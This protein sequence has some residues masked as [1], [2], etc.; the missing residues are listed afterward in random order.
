M[1]LGVKGDS[2]PDNQYTRRIGSARRAQT[3]GFSV[4]TGAGPRERYSKRIFKTGPHLASR[5][6]EDE[7]VDPDVERA[8]RADVEGDGDGDSGA[9]N[10]DEGPNPDP[11]SVSPAPTEDEAGIYAIES[12]FL[13]GSVQV[14]IA[15]GRVVSISFP[16]HVDE[17]TIGRSHPVLERIEEYLQGVSEVSFDD[18]ETALT[19]PTDQR[20]VLE[21]VR[22]IPYGE[23]IDVSAVVS[24]TPDL[25]PND[26][27]A[28][29]VVRTAL[30]ENPIPIVVP[31]HR[32]R[33]GPSAAPP[34]I[35]QKLRSLEG[36]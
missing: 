2:I 17:D 6:D 5:M 7:G 12:P 32:V 25:D 14:G 4:A 20:A 29:T 35:E 3:G 28:P 19:V 30:D 18:V 22:S 24:M 26:A 34:A 31:D 11:D 1:R 13:E 33:D 15:S 23:S 21:Q 27:D 16:D 10:Q 8:T 36:L 9:A